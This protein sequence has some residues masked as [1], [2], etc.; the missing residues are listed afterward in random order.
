MVVQGIAPSIWG[1]F[2]DIY[3]RR[4]TFIATFITYIAGNVGC[5]L[6]KDLV[7]LLT[8]RGLQAAG[9]AATISIGTTFPNDCQPATD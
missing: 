5:A 4:I 3:G 9:S 7:T 1:P 8:F 2:S 6:A